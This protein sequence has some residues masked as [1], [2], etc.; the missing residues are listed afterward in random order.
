MKHA[1]TKDLYSY[2]KRIKGQRTAPD[3]A[4][5]EPYDIQKQLKDVFILERDADTSYNFRLAGTRT[6]ALFRDELKGSGFFDLFRDSSREALETLLEAVCVDNSCAVIGIQATTYSGK[7][8]QLEMLLLPVRLNGRTDLRVM[9]SLS[10]FSM[11]QWAGV[12]PITELSILSLRLHQSNTDQNV[13]GWDSD[14]NVSDEADRIFDTDE[15]MPVY[16]KRVGHLQVIEG[17]RY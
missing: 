7:T 12:E 4:A 8:L 11:P 6:C 10:P 2:W 9:G 1:T 5:I 3:R 15:M 13:H 16:G 14:G 17:G